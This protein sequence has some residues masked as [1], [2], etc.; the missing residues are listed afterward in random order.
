[1]DIGIGMDVRFD[2]AE[3]VEGHAGSL[4]GAILGRLPGQFVDRRAPCVDSQQVPGT[5]QSSDALKRVE[6]HTETPKEDGMI[7]TRFTSVVRR[8]LRRLDGWTLTAF[9]PRYPTPR[10]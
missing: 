6:P 2:V 4:G 8:A 9:N 5:I 10:D 3:R 7:T 1:M